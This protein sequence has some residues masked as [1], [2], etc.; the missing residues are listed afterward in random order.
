MSILLGYSNKN[1]KDYHISSKN[2]NKVI[3]NLEKQLTNLGIKVEKINGNGD[4]LIWV[5]DIFILIDNTYFILNLTNNDTMNRNRATEFNE[6]INYLDKKFH[7]EYIPKNIMVEAGDI[8]INNNDIFIGINKRTD[9]K[10]IEYFQNRLSNYNIIPIY[11]TALHLD[12]IF[13][14]LNN[15]KIIYDKNYIIDLSNIPNYYETLNIRI[16]SNSNI[17]CN[18]IL[19]GNSILIAEDNNEKLIK[20]LE[21][22]NYNVIPIKYYNLGKEGGGVRCMAQW[23]TYF[24]LQKT[25]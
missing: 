15:N 4:E 5:R 14:V 20:L 24:R 22:L 25:Y 21:I 10:A 17:S 1:I 13:T 18:L 6:V 16:I 2:K 11:H 23:L 19:V 8:I 7:I 3:N 9:I 12:C